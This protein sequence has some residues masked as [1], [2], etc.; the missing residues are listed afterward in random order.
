MPRP[1]PILTLLATA[2]LAASCTTGQQ[3]PTPAPAPAPAP[4]ATS[5]PVPAP[6]T[7][8]NLL[9]SRKDCASHPTPSV[10]VE[11]CTRY[12]AAPSLTTRSRVISLANRAWGY[13]QMGRAAKALADVDQAIALDPLGGR[14]AAWNL[15]GEILRKTRKPAEAEA[16]F[17]KALS[18]LGQQRAETI[19]SGRSTAL[20][21]RSNLA[22]MLH[23][24]GR[25]A[26]ARA[27]VGEAHG[28]DPDFK[29]LQELYRFYGLA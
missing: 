21:A 26:E 15:K 4:A 5:A 22:R 28:I 23:G 29:P 8:E 7:T 9:K 13:D 25:E 19:A 18:Q 27:F 3:G 17:R 24:Q 11:A 6:G 1:L 16:A 10:V 12:L 14:A 20:L 2:A